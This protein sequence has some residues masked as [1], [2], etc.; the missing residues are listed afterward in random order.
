MTPTPIVSN[1]FRGQNLSKCYSVC[2]WLVR[3]FLHPNPIDFYQDPLALTPMQ[4][5]RKPFDA[6]QAILTILFERSSRRFHD[7]YSTL[8]KLR[9]HRLAFFAHPLSGGFEHP[10]LMPKWMLRPVL[11]LERVLDMLSRY[12]AFVSSS[13]WRRD[14]RE[15]IR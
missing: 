10:S 8:K 4:T 13:C 11:A 15:G 9:H 6:K 5:G 7:V 12:V 3:N 14:L 1:W 2:F